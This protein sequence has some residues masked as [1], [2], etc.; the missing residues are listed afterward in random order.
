MHAFALRAHLFT[1]DVVKT[2]HDILRRHDDRLTVGWRQDVVGRQHQGARLQLRFQR[3]R[4]VHRH[5]VTV[6]VSVKRSANQRMQLDCLTFDQHRLECL[7]T[8]TVQG[9]RP[10]Q[11]HRMLANHFLKNI[12]DFRHFLFN[13]AFSRLDGGCQPQCFEFIED[14]GLEKFQRHFLRQTTLVQLELRTNNDHRT[15]RIVDAFTQKVLTET[16]AFALNHVCKRLQR[17][18]VRPRHGLATTT[19]IEQRIHCFLQHPLLIADDDIR[20]LE[21]KQTLEAVVTV[22][23]AAIEIV[24]IRSRK[25]TAVERHQRT[26]FRRQDRQHFHDHPVGLDTRLIES[27]KHLQ[28]LGDFFDLGFRSR[29]SQIGTQSFNFRLEVDR[30][31]QFAHAFSPHDGGEVVTVFLDLGEVI[32]L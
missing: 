1:R 10:V 11:H 22:D 8:K 25:A 28:A 17:T 12:P 13:K 19:V 29:G 7:N 9:W 32:V 15:A 26:Q 4:H 2:E 3:Q 14:I 6:K 27:L 18:F 21:F 23:H 31:Q 20:R 24:K 16:A 5:L 30:T